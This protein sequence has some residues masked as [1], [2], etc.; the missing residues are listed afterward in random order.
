MKT[1]RPGFVNPCIV[2]VYKGIVINNNSY[3][4]Y[5][6]LDHAQLKKLI[7]AQKNNLEEKEKYL[8]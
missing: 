6:Q 2:K 5:K 4:H 3:K 1:I 7:E 8:Y